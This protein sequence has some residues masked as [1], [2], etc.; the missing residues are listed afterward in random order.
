MGLRDDRIAHAD[1]HPDG[2]ACGCQ[3]CLEVDPHAAVDVVVAVSDGLRTETVEVESEPV[4]LRQSG[5]KALESVEPHELVGG[6]SLFS[7]QSLQVE[8]G[9]TAEGVPAWWAHSRILKA[10]RSDR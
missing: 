6:P 8:V 9:T 7:G 4:V 3:V 5:E 2:E 1:V 10:C